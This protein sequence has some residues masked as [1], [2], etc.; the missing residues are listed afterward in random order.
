MAKKQLGFVV[1]Q[2]RCLGYQACE[3]ACKQEYNVEIGLRWRKV[4]E[5]V[6]NNPENNKYTFLSIACNHCEKPECLRVCPVGAYSKRKD[7]I[8]IHDQ[9]KCIGCKLCMMA[10]PYH[11]PQFNEAKGTVEKC[12]M[13]SKRIDAGMKPACIK[14]CP[15]E[16]LQVIDIN[17]YEL[18]G[19]ISDVPG[20]PDA[21]I[22]KPAVRFKPPQNGKFRGRGY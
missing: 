13:C 11:S 15:V 18:Q 2:D 12:E 8:V 9:T 17:S 6:I 16:A 19:L 3:I 20:F 21:K 10:C 7:G 22:T 1:N 14:A 4:R 5:V